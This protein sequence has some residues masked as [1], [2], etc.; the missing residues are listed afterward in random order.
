MRANFKS[1]L[2]PSWILRCVLIT[3]ILLLYSC[4]PPGESTTTGTTTETATSTSTA[5]GTSGG[6]AQFPPQPARVCTIDKYKQGTGEQ[7]LKKVDILFMMDHSGSMSDDW[8][9]VANNM[10]ELVKQLPSDTD[11]HYAVILGDVGYWKGKLYAP[12]GYPVVLDNQKMKVQEISQKLHKTFVEGMKVSDAS[13]GEALFYSL[14]YAVTTNAVANQKLGFFRPDAALSIIFMSD[15]QEVGSPFP[16]RATLAAQGLPY[17]CDEK[18]EDGIKRDY[19]DKKSI[20]VD[21]TY[22]AVKALKGD[23]PVK[24]HAFINITAQDLFKRNNRNASCLYDSLGYGYKEIVDKSKGVLF[25]IQE[26]KADGLARCGKAIKE[27]LSIIHDFQLSKPANKVDPLMISAMVDGGPVAH[28]YIASSNTV[29]LDNAGVA[30]SLVEIQHCEPDGRVA[31]N[32][33]GFTGTPAQ[34]SVGLSW[35]TAEYATNGKILWG[36][37]ANNLSNTENDA[38]IASNHAAT[39]SGLQPNTLYYFQAVSADEFGQEKASAVQ[40]FRTLP[41]WSFSGIAS[42][43]AR[44]SASVAWNTSEYPTKGKL[45]YGLAPNALNAESDFTA[46]ANAHNVNVGG[47]SPG[48]AY[49]FQIVGSDEY[50]L[51]KRSSVDSFTTQADWGIVGFEG[52]STRTAVSLVWGTPDQ[53]SAG[54]VAWGTSPSNLNHLANEGASGTSHGVVISG[55]SPDTDYYFQAVATDANSTKRS[56]VILVHTQV[57]WSI[58]NFAGTSTQTS[59]NVAWST[60]G[61]ATSGRVVWGTSDT[62]LNGTATDANVGVSHNLTISGLTPDTV[63]YFRADSVDND[64]MGKSSDVV[65]IRT[66]AVPLPTWTIGNFAGS[67]TI[68]SVTLTWATSQYATNA[69]VLW[70]DS[71]TS[72]SHQ[73]QEGSSGTSHS[74]TVGGLQADTIYYF[75]VVAT[76]DRGQEQLSDVIP[77]RTL[78]DAT[79][80]PPTNW[81]ISG[82][83]GTTTSSEV[84]LIWVTTGAETKATVMV[85]TDPSDL[86]LMQLSEN[87]Y[88][89]GSHMFTVNGLQANTVYYVKVIAADNTGKTVESSVISKRTKVSP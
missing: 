77:V 55:L 24:T 70:G 35:V 23:F 22:A 41:D 28:N 9:R 46:V 38:N 53:A 88:S 86:T 89:S 8:E 81:V 79:Q 43:T 29:H 68:D 37:A 2:H 20:N 75:Q 47:L 44:N 66:Q 73:V 49:Y 84:H 14:Y 76:D 21:S 50:G 59:V 58:S 48:T 13:Q 63:Y 10:Q 17:R 1:P 11:I 51:E 69:T 7:T 57:D 67:S 33:S 5:T 62:N 80:N 12:S 19:Y 36:N 30:N 18:F 16:S 39:V 40:S 82:F 65:A 4:V 45:L 83:D 26:N 27:S 60:L 72:L 78:V 56:N 15:E 34:T 71:L 74:V 85:G 42:Q 52:Q 3:G 31:W 54:S 61:F 6:G 64:G 25:S 32:L 87:T